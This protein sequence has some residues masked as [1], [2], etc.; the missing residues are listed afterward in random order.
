MPLP[1]YP[2]ERAPGTRWIGGWVDPRANLD[3]ME[4]RKF[5]TLPGLE[6]RPLCRPARSQPLTDY[7]IPAHRINKL[8]K[9]QI[10]LSAKI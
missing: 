2:G 4:E 7:A 9:L 5:S 3:D 6:L 10:S 1:L 8:N